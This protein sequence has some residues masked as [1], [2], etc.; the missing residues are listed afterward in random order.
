MY[1]IVVLCVCLCECVRV[2]VWHPLLRNSPSFSSHTWFLL[3]EVFMWGAIWISTDQEKKQ[4]ND[5][6]ESFWQ[7]GNHTTLSQK[8]ND[9]LVEGSDYNINACLLLERK[10]IVFGWVLRWKIHIRFTMKVIGSSDH[11]LLVGRRKRSLKCHDFGSLK[12]YEDTTLRKYRKHK[13]HY[14]CKRHTQY[15]LLGTFCFLLVCF[16]LAG[17]RTISSIKSIA[18]LVYHYNI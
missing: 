13:C 4:T 9:L 12:R 5:L 14:R 17:P 3:F 8:T 18:L 16:G 10:G 15:L 2:Y 7:K 1:L 6:T 11:C